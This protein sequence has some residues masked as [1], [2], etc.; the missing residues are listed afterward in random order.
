VERIRL[1]PACSGKRRTSPSI[2]R[3]PGNPPSA[4]VPND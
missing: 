2:S 3:N 4:A 1:H